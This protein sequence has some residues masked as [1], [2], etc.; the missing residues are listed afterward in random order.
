MQLCLHKERGLR[1]V[2]TLKIKILQIYLQNIGKH[3]R[4]FSHFVG[5]T[6]RIDTT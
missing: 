5:K 1:L 2:Y 6:E 4:I 3:K